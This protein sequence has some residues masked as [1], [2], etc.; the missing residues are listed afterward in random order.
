PV[1]A[2]QDVDGAVR[3]LDRLFLRHDD[4]SGFVPDDPVARVDLLATAIDFAPDF[5]EAFRLS[6]MR[7]DMAAEAGK[8]EL[9][10]RVQVPHGAVDH[11]AGQALHEARETSQFDTD[12]SR[13]DAVVA[14]DHRA[15]LHT[16]GRLVRT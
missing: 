6:R 3:H 4:E 2:L 10:D 11:N 5:P 16:V 13:S 9:Q 1:L 12:G 8:V 7:R 14:Q 15:W